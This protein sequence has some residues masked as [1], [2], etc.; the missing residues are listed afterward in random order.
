MIN[1]KEKKARHPDEK[2]KIVNEM[3]GDKWQPSSS[4]LD[5]DM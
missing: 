4:M 3:S 5:Q 2:N 1:K